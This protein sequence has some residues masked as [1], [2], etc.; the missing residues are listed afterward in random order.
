MFLRPEGV[1]KRTLTQASGPA[2]P[3]PVHSIRINI[4]AQLAGLF[5]DRPEG[6]GKAIACEHVQSVCLT[7]PSTHKPWLHVGDKGKEG[8]N[9]IVGLPSAPANTAHGQR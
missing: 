3:Q 2:C 4:F 9:D 7:R 6:R 1:D 5:F 8:E